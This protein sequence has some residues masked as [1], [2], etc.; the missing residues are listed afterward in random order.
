M[1]TPLLASLAN[2]SGCLAQVRTFPSTA[3]T[4][5]LLIPGEGSQ[6]GAVVVETAD[7]PVSIRT[8]AAPAASRRLADPTQVD[9]ASLLSDQLEIRDITDGS[10]MIR[11]PRRIVPARWDEKQNAYVEAERVQLG[12]QTLLLVADHV[13][14]LVDQILHAAARPGFQKVEPGSRG[15][16]GG[17][18][19][20]LD[21]QFLGRFPE[22]LTKHN[23][24]QPLLPRAATALTMSGGFVLP[25]LIR[26][27]SSMAPPEVHAVAGAANTLRVDV[28]RGSV[29]GTPVHSSTTAGAAAVIPLRPLQLEDGEYVVTLTVD[30]DRRPSATSLVRLRSSDTPTSGLTRDR[31][32]LVYRPSIGPLWPLTADLPDSGAQIDGVVVTLPLA[33]DDHQVS[34][35]PEAR[36]RTRRKQAEP[37]RAALRVGRGLGA[38]SCL[39]SGNHFFLV[40]TAYGGHP[41]TRTVPSECQTCGMVKRFPTTPAGAKKRVKKVSR[42]KPLDLT[43]IPPVDHGDHQDLTV[44]VDSMCHLGGGTIAQLQR[45]AGQVDGSALFADVLTRRLEALGHVDFRRD[46]RSLAV[47]D[48]ELTPATLAQVGP[49]LWWLVGRQPRGMTEEL[50]KL[51]SQIGGEVTAELD[52]GV[53]RLQFEAARQDLDELVGELAE[54]HG[55]IVIEENP[56]LAMAASLPRLSSIVEGLHRVPAIVADTVQ[57]WDTDAAMWVSTSSIEGVGGYRFQGYVPRY[58]VRDDADLTRGTIALA[59]AYVTKHLANLWAGDPLVGYHEPSSSVVVPL[60]ADL[61]GLYARALCV[62][63]GRLP[64]EI[65]GAHMLQYRSVPAAVANLLH[66]RLSA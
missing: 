7:G 46:P 42:E 32:S 24:F 49:D 6:G 63:A 9:P 61:P 4:L 65:P 21:V 38:A 60:G 20:Y 45:I 41:A 5:D 1:K 11:Q 23:D 13:A 66:D 33:L 31:S 28:W 34:A 16:P 3:I 40:P 48:W 58:F 25:G 27:W 55:P 30:D 15:L 2:A 14:F 8:T 57:R 10:P 26:K 53:P 39:N 44:A 62:A 54:T 22:T 17:W 35:M 64:R 52:H 51:V 47:S 37:A 18:A 50:D 59:N 19:A 12:E 36:Q 29:S 56:A 43:Q